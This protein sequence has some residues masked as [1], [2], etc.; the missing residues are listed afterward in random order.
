VVS[1]PFVGTIRLSNGR[2]AASPTSLPQSKA[3]MLPPA[4]L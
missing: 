1:A 3:P 4:G 2:R